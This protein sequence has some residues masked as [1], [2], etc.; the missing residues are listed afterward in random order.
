LNGN[1]RLLSPAV[2]A[3]VPQPEL[4]V[5]T[6]AGIHSQHYGMSFHRILSLASQKNEFSGVASKP[7]TN[8]YSS[9]ILRMLS[10]GVTPEFFSSA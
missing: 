10:V 7:G 4:A 3:L 1:G 8:K 9:T 5:D 6:Q 2:P